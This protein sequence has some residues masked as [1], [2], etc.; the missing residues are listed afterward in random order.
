MKL[1]GAPVHVSGSQGR[2]QCNLDPLL[3]EVGQHLV[4]LG[5][6]EIADDQHLLL[7]AL[8]LIDLLRPLHPGHA[9]QGADGLQVILLRHAADLD[10]H[11]H[12]DEFHFIG[13]RFICKIVQQYTSSCCHALLS[14][15]SSNASGY[16]LYHVCSLLTV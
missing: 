14:L 6:R 12:E 15:L 13:S 7:K 4:H 8:S 16:T 11:E 2:L 10:A 5:V 1:H 9:G 3:A